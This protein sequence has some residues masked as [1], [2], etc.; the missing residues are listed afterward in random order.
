E[1]IEETVGVVRGLRKLRSVSRTGQSDVVL[2]FAWGTDMDKASLE[3]RD[4]L[5]VLRL[6]LEVEPPVLLR[7]NPSTE[8]VMR[9]IFASTAEGRSEDVSELIRL[10]R[11]ADEELK[12]RLEPVEGVAAVKISGGLEDEVQV[13]IDDQ[14]LAQLKLSVNQVI[15]RLRQENVNI[16]GGR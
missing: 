7:F 3:V 8:P 6:P 11:Y 13:L 15:E 5:E 4:K 1:P 14:R 9:L 12:K 16:S 10:R 2:E